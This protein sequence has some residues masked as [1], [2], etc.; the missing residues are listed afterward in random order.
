A[1]GDKP[2]TGRRGSGVSLVVKLKGMRMQT[3]TQ[4]LQ[5]LQKMGRKGLPLTRIYRMLFSE[6]LYLVA[7]DKLRRN[8]GALTPGS[9]GE[10]IDGMRIEIIRTTIDA[11]R[12]ERFRFRPSRRT[13]IPKK[14][15]GTRPLGMPDFPEKLVQEVMRMILETYYE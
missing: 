14:S 5:A 12:Y 15:K 9:A 1:A 8:K 7:Y 3:A 11:L 2:A 6:E 10:T 13:R 4:I